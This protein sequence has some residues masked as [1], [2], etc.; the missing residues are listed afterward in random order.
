MKVA[1]SLNNEH[2]EMLKPILSTNAKD[3]TFDFNKCTAFCQYFNLFNSKKT[4]VIKD[5]DM[6]L[7]SH[8]Y[9][10]NDLNTFWLVLTKDLIMIDLCIPNNLDLTNQTMLLN[11]SS[12]EVKIVSRIIK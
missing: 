8:E 6:I 1:L 2:K 4:K 5:V 11:L 10:K 3:I 12:D 9:D 7:H